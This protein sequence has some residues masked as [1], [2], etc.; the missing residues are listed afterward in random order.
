MSTTRA[1]RT[2]DASNFDDYML[3]VSLLAL[4]TVLVVL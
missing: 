2:R 3:M 1:R 4:T